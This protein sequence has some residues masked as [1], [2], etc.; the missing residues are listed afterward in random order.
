MTS[1]DTPP[2]E[3]LIFPYANAIFVDFSEVYETSIDT[4]RRSVD[5][6]KTFVKWSGP[7]PGTIGVLY[8]KGGTEGPYSHEEI[9]QILATPEWTNPNPPLPTEPQVTSSPTPTPTETQII[10]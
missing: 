1:Q 8:M 4:L 7:T 6:T 9:L 2:R 5:G 10:P 3:Y